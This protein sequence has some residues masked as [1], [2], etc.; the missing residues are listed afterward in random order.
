MLLAATATLLITKYIIPVKLNMWQEDASVNIGGPFT[1]IDQTG[2]TVTEQDF[3]G[4]VSLYFFGFISCPD[5]CP[6]QLMLYADMVNEH[7]QLIDKVNFIFVSVDPERDTQEVMRSYI[8][9]FHPAFIGL[10]GA[11]EN[12]A[13]ITKNF[14]V[15]YKKVERADA[16]ELY[17]VDHTGFSY[18]MGPNGHYITHFSRASSF[19]EIEKVLTSFL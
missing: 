1:A 16:P 5:I 8:S 3:L 12:I 4:R 10:T 17:T 19:E 13:E 18:L 7:P 9:A 14:K 2:K 15:Y 11:K 6:T